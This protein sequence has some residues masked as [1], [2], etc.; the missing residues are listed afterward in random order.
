VT[1]VESDASEEP[2]V[3]DRFGQETISF[4]VRVDEV[5]SGGRPIVARAVPS[6]L[7]RSL[8]GVDGDT[9]EPTAVTTCESTG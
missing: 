4:D 3:V 5:P 6:N 7:S 8:Y 1:L 2:I 9:S